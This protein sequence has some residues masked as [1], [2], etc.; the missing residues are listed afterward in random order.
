M[1][2]LKTSVSFTRFRISDSVPASIWPE[3]IERLRR[4]SFTDIDELPE[5]RS[6]GW[7]AFEDMLDVSFAAEPVEKG[8]YI[9]FSLR[10]DT[11]RVPP[12]VIKK[13]LA[14]AMKREEEQNRE[15]GRKFVSR[16]RKKELR[17]QVLLRLRSRFLPIPAEFQVIWNTAESLVYFAST[18]QKM[19]DLFEELFVRTFDLHIIPLSPYELATWRLGDS[20]ALDV[21]EST[22]F[23]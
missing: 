6:F 21:I 15:L 22:Q 14:L 8:P 19:L 5:E 13:H 7:T 12:A 18:Q 16:D 11:R 4:N 3:V 2:F 20:T 9:A 10:L 1:S 23:A 17:E